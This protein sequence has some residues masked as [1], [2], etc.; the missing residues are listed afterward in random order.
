M[1]IPL[2]KLKTLGQYCLLGGLIIAV[3]F[4]VSNFKEND[5]GKP[6]NVPVPE[7]QVWE[8]LKNQEH[9]DPGTSEDSVN[10]YKDAM[11]ELSE[12]FA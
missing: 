7:E 9:P 4:V 2:R 10:F 5:L 11:V 1:K 6:K 8:G 3:V 12:S